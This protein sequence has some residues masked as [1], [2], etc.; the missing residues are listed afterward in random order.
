M[1]SKPGCLPSLGSPTERE[2]GDVCHHVFTLKPGTLCGEACGCL[3]RQPPMAAPMVRWG[4][5]ARRTRPRG[6][7]AVLLPARLRDQN[8]PFVMTW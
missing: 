2:W 6:V 7:R 1:E 8:H 3:G 5:G 4:V